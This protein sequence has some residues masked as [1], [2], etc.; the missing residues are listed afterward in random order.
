M[1]EE[2][3]L[4]ISIG[5][6]Q[7]FVAA[8][9]NYQDLWYG[10]YLLS[11]LA[12]EVITVIQK[13]VH[14]E[15]FIV[16]ASQYWNEKRSLSNKIIVIVPTEKLDIILEEAEESIKQYLIQKLEY[17]FNSKL[18][19]AK[20]RGNLLERKLRDY[21][22]QEKA[23]EQ[24]QEIIEFFAVSTA[25]PKREGEE[26]V[27][28]KKWAKEL[29][30]KE[31]TLALWTQ[32]NLWTMD[33]DEE[34]PKSS[35]NEQRDSII[36][37]RLYSILQ[38]SQNEEEVRLNRHICRQNLDITFDER[39]C[40][41]GLIKR[42]G[43]KNELLTSHSTAHIAAQSL[44]RILNENPLYHIAFEN[45]LTEL[46]Q[47]QKPPSS[48]WYSPL[49]LK[50][51]VEGFYGKHEK[52]NYDGAILYKEHLLDLV[53]EYDLSSTENIEKQLTQI[54]ETFFQTIGKRP[55][56]L[57]GFLMAKGDDIEYLFDSLTSVEEQRRL[58]QCLEE[59]ADEAQE[60]VEQR[61]G[62]SLIYAGDDDILAL[63][64]LEAALSCSRKLANTFKEKLSYFANKDFQL[65]LSVGLV[66]AHHSTS[67]GAVRASALE[68]L[69]KAKE[70]KNALA[71][72]LDKH[73]SSRR[74]LIV[75][76]WEEGEGVLPLDW[77]LKNWQVIFFHKELNHGFLYKLEEI[78]HLIK[79]NEDFESEET[80]KLKERALEELDKI[81][82]YEEIGP[83]RSSGFNRNVKE[84]L[85]NFFEKTIDEDRYALHRLA[86]ELYIALELY[87]AWELSRA[88]SQQN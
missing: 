59:F 48:H 74:R 43:L 76:S 34:T 83:S 49:L 57:Y 38:G 12:K 42:I 86:D 24:I 7:D 85:K 4:I 54:L 87:R 64:P 66:L 28:A 25:C 68:T 47:L 23:F 3:F 32:S 62:G 19:Y 50:E 45:L 65:T 72:L 80:K 35:L 70:R 46:N 84:T 9:K 10:S 55:H 41:L 61:Y 67:L 44:L 52:K 69:E 18:K 29:L 14:Q 53:R 31:K 82:S 27:Q 15:N 16:P 77:R 5:P 56:P 13:Y 60:I 63:L 33:E 37:E 2:S 22:N 88:T 21:L 36:D 78:A 75:G 40:A 51:D 26:Y 71:L 81:M 20:L 8:A 1:H 30:L 39:L 58:S 11:R 6:I 73:S 17:L 79:D